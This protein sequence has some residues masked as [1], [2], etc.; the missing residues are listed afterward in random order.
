MVSKYYKITQKSLRNNT[1]KSIFSCIY[2][3]TA[4]FI[5]SNVFDRQITFENILPQRREVVVSGDGNYFYRVNAHWKD[6]MSDEKNMRKSLVQVIDCL[7]KIQR[8]L[9]CN[10]F[11]SNSLKDLVRKARSRELRQKLWTY[12]QLCIARDQFVSLI[13]TEERVQSWANHQRWFF[14]IDPNKEV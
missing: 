4:Y 1:F 6:K 3:C 13:A 12:H 10:F 7:R 11:F 8:S 2:T 14:L 5:L 9:S